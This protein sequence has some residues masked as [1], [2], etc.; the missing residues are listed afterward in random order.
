ME[1]RTAL[2]LLIAVNITAI[3]LNVWLVHGNLRLLDHLRVLDQLLTA[4]CHQAFMRDHQPI[5]QA[6]TNSMG[7]FRVE[8]A[9]TRREWSEGAPNVPIAVRATPPNPEGPARPS[10]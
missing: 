5:W 1:L 7:S 4:I 10:R 8:V 6:W 2:W 9:A 3:A